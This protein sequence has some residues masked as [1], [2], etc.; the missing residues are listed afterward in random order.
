MG[1]SFRHP[2]RSPLGGG[3]AVWWVSG[4]YIR[5]MLEE[6]PVGSGNFECSQRQPTRHGM[7]GK[8]EEVSVREES[9]KAPPVSNWEVQPEAFPRET[10]WSK[11][12][13]GKTIIATS[14]ALKWNGF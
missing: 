5:G 8:P 11:Y 7:S 10:N 1:V 14:L 2:Q 13:R 6:C 9:P 4:Y 12:S 3:R